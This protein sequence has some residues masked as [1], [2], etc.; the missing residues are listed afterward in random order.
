MSQN[1]EIQRIYDLVRDIDERLKLNLNPEI[2]DD[3][4]DVGGLWVRSGDP[5]IEDE[6]FKIAPIG[7]M[8]GF[9]IERGIEIHFA[10]RL[11]PPDYDIVH[12]T[13]VP[14]AWSAAKW[15]ILYAIE[16]RI[17]IIWN[18]GE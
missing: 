11:E 7:W 18:S 14:D 2:K 9:V 13:T 10:T 6:C 3:T 5:D 16:D 17:D 8:P 12:I 15:L 1:L 4:V